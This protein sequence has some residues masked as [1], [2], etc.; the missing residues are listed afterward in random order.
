[1]DQKE[2]KKISL[3]RISK[4]LIFILF[5]SLLGAC[6]R[7]TI[8]VEYPGAKKY[9]PITSAEKFRVVLPNEVIG[10]DSTEM[11]AYYRVG[12]KF[13]GI[14]CNYS[15]VLQDVTT[16]ARSMGAHTVKIKKIEPP[17]DNSACYRMEAIFYR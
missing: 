10:R 1:M 17:D 3:T 12:L 7:K 15:D 16:K 14:Y 13:P 4:V 9:P 8:L 6:A 5:I 11:L 2:I